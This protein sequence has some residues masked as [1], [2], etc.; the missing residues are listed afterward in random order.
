MHIALHDVK[1]RKL[2][3]GDPEH[4]AAQIE[5]DAEG[6]PDCMEQIAGSTSHF[7]DTL[8]R[9][10][11]ELQKLGQMLIVVPAPSFESITPRS[12]SIKHSTSPG[13]IA[14]RSQAAF[15]PVR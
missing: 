3:P 15:I 14:D 6:R 10:N 4:R 12:Q 2:C 11:Q 5:P 1:V 13:R 9:G 7:Q 8:S